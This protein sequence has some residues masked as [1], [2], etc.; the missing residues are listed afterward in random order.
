MDFIESYDTIVHKG[1]NSSI[2]GL[3]NY[4]AALPVSACKSSN[5]KRYAL[6]KKAHH[7]MEDI[8]KLLIIDDEK[9]VR[10]SIRL[11]VD[12]DSLNIN[13]ILES[14]N[15]EEAIEILK[16]DEPDIIILDIMMPLK[17]G[18]ALMDWM[19]IQQIQSNIIVLSGFDDFNFV[20]HTL[21]H[22]A[23]DYL[24]KPINPQHLEDALKKA[25]EK[26]N[27]SRKIKAEHQELVTAVNELKPVY[28][29]KLL[30]NFLLSPD[31]V[32][33]TA[34][35]NDF[36]ELCH[37]GS[38]QVIVT[39]IDLMKNREKAADI[40]VDLCN[41][42]LWIDNKGY[43]FR[44]IHHNNEIVLLYWNEFMD[45]ARI[46]N[47]I[48]QDLWNITGG[49]L[50]FGLGSPVSFPAGLSQSYEKAVNALKHGN[51]LQ[52]SSSRIHLYKDQLSKQ[53]STLGF[54]EYKEGLRLAVRSG[55]I[56]QIQLAVQNWILHLSTRDNITFLQYKWWVEEYHLTKHLW[57]EEFT[58]N[59]M[60]DLAQE[61][62]YLPFPLHSDKKFSLQQLQHL[63]TED[64]LIF[65]KKVLEY[66]TS[67]NN[68]IQ[69]ISD[70]I[71]KNYRDVSLSDISRHF[72]LNRE[73]ISRRFKQEF[74]ITIVNYVS[75][76]RIEKAKVLLLNPHLK[77]AEVGST[78][79]YDDE[80]Y[81]SRVFKKVT[82]L[83]PTDYR[84]NND[85]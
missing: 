54:S 43:A 64:L 70:Y 46:L 32:I 66:Q 51:L 27:E 80:K 77:I 72:H 25:I 53:I 73:H 17:D 68:I 19:K 45:I 49:Q 52:S 7:N 18:L 38:C 61:K 60:E 85:L 79:G 24:L 31:T 84:N 26:R 33:N 76:I 42:Y 39:D 71:R 30:S 62:N 14:R 59:H 67:S 10:K 55:N 1:K 21:K 29:D 28:L 35:N 15:G 58:S 3:E 40:V 82:G 47:Q 63:I 56:G 11:L 9:H 36:F 8:M 5:S 83:S 6:T 23:V 37:T 16:S 57:L 2:I 20:R 41:Q 13:E 69:E 22:G 34:M 65:S 48:N 75:Q 78:V 81:F 44:N 12:W 4:L 50:E 74:G